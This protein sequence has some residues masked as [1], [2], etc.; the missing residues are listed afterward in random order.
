MASKI[1]TLECT[2]FTAPEAKGVNANELIGSPT[3]ITLVI[4]DRVWFVH[5]Y[6]VLDIEGV[7]Q[8]SPMNQEGCGI[9]SIAMDGL[10][11]FDSEEAEEAKAI[12][13]AIYVDEQLRNYA[14]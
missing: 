1:F 11:F 2:H 5:S 10:S 9:F 13:Q 7:K 8:E 14:Q 3:E 6:Q 4:A 12:A